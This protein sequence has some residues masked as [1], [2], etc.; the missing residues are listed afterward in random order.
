MKKLISCNAVA[1]AL[2]MIIPV[3]CMEPQA[4]TPYTELPNDMWC[5][6]IACCTDKSKNVLA[7][8]C[9]KLGNFSTRINHHIYAH[10][11]LILSK[12]DLQFGLLCATHYSNAAAVENLLQYRARPNHSSPFLKML[13]LNIATNQQNKRLIT[14][15]KEYD[16][17]ADEEKPPI[18]AQA[19]YMGDLSLLNDYLESKESEQHYHTYKNYPIW[20]IAIF[21]GHTHIIERLLKDPQI[22]PYMD[23]PGWCK[24]TPLFFTALH[25]RSAIATLLLQAYPYT[26]NHLCRAGFT[27]LH[28]AVQHKHYH[29]AEILLK[30]PA[31]KVNLCAENRNSPLHTAVNNGDL[32]MVTLLLSSPN[33]C[34]NIKNLEN[35][36]PLD[37]AKQLLNGNKDKYPPET[38]RD[39]IDLLIRKGAKTFFYLSKIAPWND[40]TKKF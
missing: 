12:K 10:S 15:L 24:T 39:I 40:K 9:T 29:I 32:T 16:A 31:I 17:Q 21:N 37:S 14:L 34:L 19:V 33:I 4:I 13:P 38:V 3:I 18:Y 23:S 22:T 5:K 2:F 36:T 26:L 20:H 11:P 6:I 1:Y 28:A 35:E 27:A 25:N 8:T 7:R 30:H